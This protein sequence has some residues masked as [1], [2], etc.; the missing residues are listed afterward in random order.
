MVVA[1][2]EKMYRQF[3]RSLDDTP[4]Q[5]I[6]WTAPDGKVVAYELLTV[7]Y[8]TKSASYLATR[9]FQQL[10]NYERKQ[11]PLAALTIEEDVYMDDVISGADNVEAAI[12]LRRQIDTMM[13]SGGL[14]L[15]KWASNCPDVL[16]GIPTENLAL[17]DSNGI[18]WDQDAE[19]KTLGSTWLPNVDCFRFKFTIPPLTPFQILTKRQLLAFIARLFDPLGLLGATITAAKIFM[20]RLWCLKNEQGNNLQWDGML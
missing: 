18:D 3:L 14:K 13:I 4:L 20:Q 11:F 15:R 10:A 6:L 17:P 8:G 2:V 12:E 1:D 9:A 16:K 19:V 5:C 7:T